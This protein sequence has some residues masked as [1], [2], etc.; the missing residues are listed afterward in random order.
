MR[1][2]WRFADAHSAEL[3]AR[4]CRTW[5]YYWDNEF[6]KESGLIAELIFKVHHVFLFLV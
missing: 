4:V 6:D 5:T 1:N 3:A 2:I